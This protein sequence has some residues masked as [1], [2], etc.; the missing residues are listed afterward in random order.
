MTSFVTITFTHM[1]ILSFLQHPVPMGE[2]VLFFCSVILCLICIVIM[3]VYLHDM[4]DVRIQTIIEIQAGQRERIQTN[5]SLSDAQ[6]QAGQRERIQTNLTFTNVNLYK[7]LHDMRNQLGHE[8]KYLIYA[9]MRGCGGFAD[10]VKGMITLYV[11]S[12]KLKR[13]FGIY[14]P[15]PC[16]LSKMLEPSK[17]NWTVEEN[18]VTKHSRH[19]QDL[20]FSKH[21]FSTY[22]QYLNQ[23]V[24]FMQANA[25]IS[26]YRR[27]AQKVFPHLFTFSENI[28]SEFNEFKKNYIGRNKLVC[29]HIRIGKNPTMK[30]TLYIALGNISAIWQF[31]QRYDKDGHVIYI[32]SDSQ[33]VHEA[34][35]V[36]F[37]KRYVNIPGRIVHID[38]MADDKD[39]S[40]FH[41]VVSE[42]Y[43]LSKCDVLLL[44]RSGYG[45]LASY[46][47]NRKNGLYCYKYGHVDKCEHYNAKA[48]RVRE[49]VE[50]YI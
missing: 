28:Q 39:C 25:E 38:K 14:H 18:L 2:Q 37:P 11:L 27:H 19:Y 45:R 41:K 29:S 43:V 35:K 22:K 24:L 40:G 42:F 26:H 49:K 23:S 33:A 20:T 46:V 30:D 47:R 16:N 36:K 48:E 15:R 50:V 13:K 6:V 12:R 31:L 3:T 44:T 8:E 34:A 1:C 7:P 32:A 4:R 10:R 21:F 9:C 5:L 17:Y